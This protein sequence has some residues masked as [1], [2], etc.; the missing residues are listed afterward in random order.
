MVPHRKLNKVAEYG[1]YALDI[2]KKLTL[3]GETVLT[4]ALLY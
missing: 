1:N 4:T 3:K 2:I